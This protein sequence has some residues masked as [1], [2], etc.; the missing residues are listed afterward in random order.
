MASTVGSERLGVEQGAAVGEPELAVER[1]AYAVVDV[2]VLV[3]E[4]DVELEG[5]H[6]GGDVVALDAHERA[7]APRVHGACTHP[8]VDGDVVHD[9]DAPGAQHG[10]GEQGAV[11][12][13]PGEHR[14][15][16]EAEPGRAVHGVGHGSSLALR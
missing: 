9:V 13:H 11:E 3:H 5:L 8:E 16:A 1:V 15:V 10:L 4:A 12:E 7:H 14:L 2:H 6:D